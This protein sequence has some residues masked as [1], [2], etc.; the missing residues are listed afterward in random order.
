MNDPG[1]MRLARPLPTCVAMSMAPSRP[2]HL[3]LG[4]STVGHRGAHRC[5][6]PH[7]GFCDPLDGGWVQAARPDEGTFRPGLGSYRNQR[8]VS[9]DKNPAGGDSRRR[10]HPLAQVVP[11]QD[12]QLSPRLKHDGLARLTEEI[13]LPIARH[14]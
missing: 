3:G 10:D 4:E 1:R 11:L 8:F 9:P 13:Y 12:V 5:V 7:L 2:C 14:R 6:A